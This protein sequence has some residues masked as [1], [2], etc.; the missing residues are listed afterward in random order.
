MKTLLRCLMLAVATAAVSAIGQ[1]VQ[2]VPEYVPTMVGPN[3]VRADL[4]LM[5]RLPNP[6]NPGGPSK[7]QDILLH[8]E[9]APYSAGSYTLTDEQDVEID[10]TPQI[11]K[12]PTNIV[13]MI[14]LSPATPLDRNKKYFL[15]VKPNVL[16]FQVGTNRV[17]NTATNFEISGDMIGPALDYVEKRQAGTSKITLGGGTPGGVLSGELIFDRSQ[18]LN[19]GWMNLRLKGDADIT[20]DGS[21]RHDFFNS[22]VGEGM[23]YWPFRFNLCPEHPN[24]SELNITGTIESDQKL[25]IANA[26]AGLK[27]AWYVNF[28]FTDALGHIFVPES[29][30]VPPLIVLSYD[31]LKNVKDETDTAAN[32]THR[33]GALLRY[34]IPVSENLDLSAFPALGGKY[35]LFLDLEVKGL[36]DSADDKIHDQSW[37]SLV[38][39]RPSGPD[40][41]KP[42]F[43]LTWARGQAPPT[44]D[45]VNAF[46]AGFMLSF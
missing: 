11:D 13:G 45:Q 10:I 24:Y 27:W 25:T 12:D 8:H 19:V 33:A 15:Q 3:K 44:F 29:A 43:V 32:H 37:V 2:I 40:R 9:G 31:Y 20:L 35:N 30:N 26:G 6:A 1:T 39:E 7:N 14:A 21:D 17:S 16:V 46:L 28:P 22:V 42:A 38:F 23:L 5:F 4:T 41:F 18:F 34:K 36:Y